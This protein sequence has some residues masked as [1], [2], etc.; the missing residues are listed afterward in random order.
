M[1]LK[2]ISIF[3]FTAFFLNGQL[4]A[5]TTC[6]T[7]GQNPETAFPVCGTTVF[8]QGTV[9]FCGGVMVP[10]LCPGPGTLITD[11]NPY[12]YKF[13]CFVSGKL[14]FLI[15]PLFPNEDYDWQLWD[16][17][18][19]NPRDIYTDLS[20]FVVCN[21]SGEKGQTGASDFLGGTSLVE[22]E[23]TGVNLFSKMPDLIAGRNY[24][25][26]VSHFEDTPNGYALSFGGVGSTAVITDT[27]PPH[28]NNAFR[29]SCDATQI[30]LGLNK[31]MK[32]SSLA[33]DG[34][35]FRINPP[36]ANVISA[37]G[38]GCT[39]GF[40][41]DSV[42]LTFNVP[43][44]VGNYQLIAQNGVDGNT[45]T[46]LCDNGI[47]V[48]EELPFTILS[49]VPVPIDSLQYDH[50][51]TDSLLLVLPN[52]IKCNSVALDG[53][54]FF[55]TGTY[56]VTVMNATPLN[57]SGGL[58]KLVSIKLNGP[59]ILPG[60]FNLVL[61]VG[62][63]GNTLL[64]EC[65][66][67][68]IAGDFAAFNIVPKPVT[69]FSF[70]STCLPDGLISFTNGS[71]ISDGTQAAFQYLWDFGDIGSG[72]ANA[73]TLPS[74]THRY[75]TVGPYTVILRVT[76]G[77][78]CINTATRLVNTIH[79]Q[80]KTAFGFNK[81]AICLGDNIVLTDSTDAMD[82]TTIQWFWNLGDGGLGSTP[83]ITHIYNT[84]SSY[85]VSLYTINSHGCHSDTLVKRITVYPFPTVD[86]GPD[87]TVLQG[88]SVLLQATVSN[89]PL[90]L[91]WTPSQYLD[92]PN[93]VRTRAR[94]IMND[95]TYSIIAT[96][97]GGCSDTDQVF[98]KVLKMPWIPN[99]F[100]P[101]NDGIN[102]YWEIKY[103]EDY[104]QNHVQVFTRTGQ[105][106]FESR[107]IYKAWDGTK[108]GKPLPVD[109]YYYIIEP[110]YGRD[111]ITGYVTI[112]K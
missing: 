15:T 5:Q 24:L 37:V 61:K 1:L 60:N 46:D 75:N 2:K 85:D 100:T 94:N 79:P 31:R 66:T 112:V 52:F 16:V 111:P 74:P 82:G 6:T 91:M 12:W 28:M 62:S 47:P 9:P 41:M 25:L 84:E 36:V 45:V 11:K 108:K 78:G 49:P 86:A 34:S 65:D 71:T 3:V 68:S 8:G 27:L 54:D 70:S 67:A 53:S 19:R 26:L 103:M 106:V 23:G 93:I 56:P 43:L 4:F 48:D 30:Q 35:D 13:T 76:S 72:T 63:D 87:Q 64:S 18:G 104:K 97:L 98:I 17:T 81:P 95:I 89:Q 42:I 10:S 99:T 32:C 83:V 40:D 77:R 90:Q 107:G 29:S 22:C 14:S 105:L 7:L 101:N 58:T 102:D 33:L 55:V 96:A 57:C 69:A 73:S 92:N 21:W 110:G 50:C 51:T 88:G 20:L 109:V 44:P 38:I 39:S 59:H 80:P